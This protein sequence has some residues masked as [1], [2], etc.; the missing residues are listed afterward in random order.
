MPGVPGPTTFPYLLGLVFAACGAWL[1]ISPIDLME[2]VAKAKDAAT[3]APDP[4]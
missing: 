1:L 4:P 2:R 3:P